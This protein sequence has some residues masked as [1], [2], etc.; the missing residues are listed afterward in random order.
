M[1]A[2]ATAS[3]VQPIPAINN[4]EGRR[5]ERASSFKG[6]YRSGKKWKAQIQIDGRQHYLGVFASQQE[7]ANCYKRFAARHKRLATSIERE[8]A[9]TNFSSSGPF[10]D[11]MG[12]N[13]KEMMAH[14]RGLLGRALH[15]LARLTLH[16]LF[17]ANPQPALH[18]SS[19]NF[20]SMSIGAGL[21]VENTRRAISQ[22]LLRSHLLAHHLVSSASTPPPPPTAN[23]PPE[24]SKQLPESPLSSSFS[25]WTAPEAEMTVVDV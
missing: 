21:E 15:M 16:L 2:N 22:L 8:Q 3:P 24:A 4:P 9:E 6:V 20:P 13:S 14:G 17:A 10:D 23:P 7:A 1:R 18:I 12:G 19:S 25:P 5:R 11:R